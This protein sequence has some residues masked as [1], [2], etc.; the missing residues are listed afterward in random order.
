M[1]KSL[2]NFNINRTKALK[3]I[4]LFGIISLFGDL[5]YEG[6]RSVNGPYLEIL[7]ANA[8][9]IGLIAG[10]GEFLGYGIRLVSGYFSDKTKAYWFFT[11]VGYSLLFTV[12]LLSLAGVWQLAAIF[13]VS[14]RI[15]KA[16][17][18]PAKDTILSQATKQIG[19]GMGFA[20][21]EVFDQIGAFI[22]PL[23]FSV[24]FFMVGTSGNAISDY[25]TGYSLFWIPFIIMMI[26]VLFAYY[27]TK[28]SDKLETSIVKKKESDKLSRV[29]WLYTL[30][31]FVTTFGFVNF[32]LIGYHLKV[33]NILP[34]AQIPLF[35]A[36]A[37][38]V[39]A[40]MALI[41][42]KTYDNLKIK[43]KN[44]NAGLFAL[45]FI[46]IVSIFIPFFA[47]SMNYAFILFSMIL[48]GAVMG[49]QETIMKSAIA[50]ITPLKK[51]GTGYGIFSTS[52][53]LAIFA[54]SVMVGLLYEY[55]I[56][57]LIT[58]IIVIEIIAIPFFFI[59]WKNSTK[60][61]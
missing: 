23:I 37:M 33:Q 44:E 53:G 47:F 18:N 54:G 8:A 49:A 29:F 42:G 59:M 26:V 61:E 4:I 51:R 60:E 27:I 17:R 19:T 41:I 30:F 5:I 1:K 57:I 13:I 25:Q 15:G 31:S 36:I 50:D 2:T 28:H 14:E 10:I 12:P 34:D 35:Y 45:L 24:F 32:A 40:V 46:P 43:R 38:A 9:I 55:S 20:L 21:V 22:G 7:G 39:D 16:L 58:V 52:Y 11:I 48:W 6:A 3:L 56:S